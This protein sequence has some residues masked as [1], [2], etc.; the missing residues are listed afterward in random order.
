MEKFYIKLNLNSLSIFFASP[1]V[2]A[3]VTLHTKIMDNTFDKYLYVTS[4]RSCRWEFER[5]FL[6]KIKER[7]HGTFLKIYQTFYLNE[8]FVFP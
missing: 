4:T 2:V 5:V 7:S 3:F 6:A 8:F 1:A